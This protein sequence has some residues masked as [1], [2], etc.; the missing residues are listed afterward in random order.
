M[1]KR[2]VWLVGAI[3]IL[4]GIGMYLAFGQEKISISSKITNFAECERAGFPIGESYPRQCWTPDG[5]HFVEEIGD[6]TNERGQISIT[7][8]MACLPKIGSGPQ[9]EECA[10]GLKT[11]ENRYYGIKNL[12]SIDEE[13]K[14]FRGGKKIT[15]TGLL[16]SKEMKGPD[17]N[18]YDVVG[19][20]EVISAEEAGEK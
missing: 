2:S 3:I 8:E 5:R 18:R 4:T 16:N 20:I 10:I 17:G 14:L 19:V 13:Y 6:P 1:D 9:T 7:G 12:T 15:V 11:E